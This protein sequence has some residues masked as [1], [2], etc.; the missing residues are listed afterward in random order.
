MFSNSENA[1]GANYV[2]PTLG[3]GVV[4]KINKEKIF[5]YGVGTLNADTFNLLLKY[6]KTT[7]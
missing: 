4:L 7:D 5:R 6:T 1:E 3:S 2:L